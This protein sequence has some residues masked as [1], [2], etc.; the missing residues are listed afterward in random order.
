MLNYI[1]GPDVKQGPTITEINH[2]NFRNFNDDIQT[3]Y[4]TSTPGRYMFRRVGSNKFVT[5]N[6]FLLELDH[7]I[8]KILQSRNTWSSR[9]NL[10][11]LQIKLRTDTWIKDTVTPTAYPIDKASFLKQ[12]KIKPYD[13]QWGFISTYKM[14]KK[15]HHLKGLLLDAKA[16]SG[17][18]QPLHSKIK[19]P[20]GW[21]TMGEMKVGT[22][23]IARDGSVTRVTGVHPQGITKVYRVHFAD[24]RYTDCHPEH[25]WK[26]YNG[27]LN[28]SLRTRSYS[29]LTQE[30]KDNHRWRIYTTAELIERLKYP[31]PRLY[32]P[33]CES[34]KNADI[35]LPM[36]PYL[37]GVILGDGSTSSGNTDISKPYQQLFDKIQ[38]KL[39]DWME[40]NWVDNTIFRLR[41]KKTAERGQ[42]NVVRE[43]LKTID[44][45][46]LRSY[47]KFIPDVYFN[48]ST[49]QRLELLRGLL[50]TDGTVGKAKCVSFSSSSEKLSKGVQ[51]LVRSLGGIAKISTRIPHYTYKGER[52]E[53]RMDY[54][55]LI[56]FPN[57]ELLFTLD[58]KKERAQKGQYS[59]TL[60]LKIT[61]IEELPQQE[62]QCIT[63]EDHEHLYIT[64]DFVVTHNTFTSLMWTRLTGNKKHII[65]CPDA[66]INT[67]WKLHM[68]EKVFV[69]PPKYWSTRQNKP[70]DPSCEYFLIHIDYTRNPDFFKILDQVFEA[71]GKGGV[72][73]VVDESHNF[74]ELSSKQTQNIIKAAD[75]YPFNDALPMSGTP[76]KAM[77]RE[78]YSIFAL[79]DP[80]FKG[81]AR[82][83]FM[84]SYGLSRDKLNSL[85][86]H[87]LGR[88]RYVIDSLFDMG[89]EP[90]VEIVPVTVPNGERFT[91]KAIRLEMFAYIQNRVKFYEQNMPMF[92]AFFNHVLDDYESYVKDDNGK[93]GELVKYKQIVNRFRTHGYNNFTDSADS[94]YAKNV[95]IDIEARLRGEQLKQFRN[96]KSAVKYVGLKIRGEALGNVLGKARIEAV[97][98]VVAH[99]GLPSM[100]NNVEKKTLIF[101]SYVDVLNEVYSVLNKEGFKPLLIYGDADQ[102]KDI[103]I[104]RFDTEPD[105]NPAVT[106]FRSL[107]ESAHMVVANQEILMDA[108]WRDYELKQTKARIF[109]QGQDKPCFFWMIELDTGKELNIMT[110]SIDI[111]QWSRDNVEELLSQSTLN[112]P[113]L[114]A[115]GGEEALELMDFELPT[116]PLPKSTSSV[117][118]LF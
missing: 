44:V 116:V 33:L 67:V 27:A 5:D 76:L 16:G 6:F 83:R 18:A 89:E 32:V 53:G 56:R 81:N 9:K 78:A 118:D 102:S 43:Q 88:T 99:A 110:R 30:E 40:C 77:A 82:E 31:R 17:K 4:G 85:L 48:G 64:D 13:T 70:F 68:E 62:T 28:K 93:L 74:N 51:Y 41:R 90:P 91:L 100:I 104:K 96:I 79:I 87:R 8:T 7:L 94:Q 34:E 75:H 54:R 69:D 115:I 50:D 29:E 109:R 92:L 105:L 97:R 1:F 71:A 24:G 37:L 19:V 59:D 11:E 111:L 101:T 2:V 65:I 42:L 23:V 95:E 47:E 35:K 86:A 46:G 58:H 36:D 14:V 98:A 57:P 10:N 72:S 117:L 55:V 39:P 25:L 103:L 108:P 112:N 63:V 12:F 26:I 107:R 61:R 60:K 45:M 106:T 49:E 15:S 20:G 52:K 113:S 73:L 80:F 38:S 66:G 114:R 3:A 21:S 84:K 22:K